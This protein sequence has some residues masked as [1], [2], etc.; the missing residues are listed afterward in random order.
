MIHRISRGAR[1]LA[2]SLGAGVI[3][4]LAVAATPAA[5]APAPTV[6][7][8]SGK[9]G[10]A[11]KLQKDITAALANRRGT[12]AV[13][14][15]DRTTN[16]TCTL[17]ATTAFD[18][19]STVKVTVLAT[20]L[21]DAKKHNRYL[22]STETSLAT[23]MI[24]QSDN[25]STTKLWNQLGLTKIKGFL[26]AA[27]MTKTTPGTGG[28]WGLTQ[29]NVT[30]EQKLLKLITAKNAVLSDNS[31]AYVL[32]LMGQVIS[33]QR[34]GTPAGAPSTVAVH[35]KNGWLSRSSNAWRV[36]SLGTFNGGGHDYMMS[37]LTVG[38]STMDYGVATIQGVAKAIHKDLV[39]VT[40]NVQRFTPT[41]TPT[42]AF[43]AVP[44]S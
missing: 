43:P 10:L 12:V 2:V 20:L 39:P 31:R 13:G 7:C 1:V 14:L 34:W 42:E 41:S 40:A 15:Y 24:T 28:Y 29:I 44:A 16:T 32:K 18:S 33:S 22:T 38:S 26:T 37:V 36:H 11:A 23:K 6:S 5:A 25:A 19:A 21:W 4:P 17:R 9:A 35:V 30:D 3:V 8:T 27:G